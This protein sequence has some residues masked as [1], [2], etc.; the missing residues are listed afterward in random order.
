MGWRGGSGRGRGREGDGGGEGEG[1]RKRERK[2]RGDTLPHVRCVLR[3]SA[4]LLQ[5]ASTQ[6]REENNALL[7]QQAATDCNRLQQT[8]TDCNRLQ[9]TAT[10]CNT[11]QHTTTQCNEAHTDNTPDEHENTQYS[12]QAPQPPRSVRAVPPHTAFCAP[13]PPTPA[14]QHT[15]RDTPHAL[16]PCIF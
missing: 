13:P 15:V 5:C 11:L 4:L 12:A 3:T 10:H 7:L 8:P 9:Q 1:E 2:K 14:K 6:E 16:P